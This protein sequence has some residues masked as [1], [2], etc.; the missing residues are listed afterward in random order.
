[1]SSEGFSL[2]DFEK[3]ATRGRG[4]FFK[5]A[6]SG[7][8]PLNLPAPVRDAV[9]AT[10][11]S[12]AVI[13]DHH[14]QES[15]IR[16]DEF[17]F[18]YHQTFTF[19]LGKNGDPIPPFLVIA[20]RD[21]YIITPNFS[22]IVSSITYENFRNLNAPDQT[23]RGADGV[24]HSPFEETSEHGGPGDQGPT[25]I[26]GQTMQLPPL[27]ILFQTAYQSEQLPV[28]AEILAVRFPGVKGGRGGKG[29]TGDGGNGGNAGKG[30]KG[31]NGGRG[32]NGGTVLVGAPEDMLHKYA[33]FIRYELT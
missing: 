6:A 17:H 16:T 23:Q 12:S 21:L 13:G 33:G 25:G 31:G 32:G 22:E 14:V 20:A 4:Y 27:Y 1:M 3:V 29:G 19:D 10:P 2:A 8:S 7:V 9:L 5:P 26:V 18:Q 30:G 15:I 28:A 24:S 11:K